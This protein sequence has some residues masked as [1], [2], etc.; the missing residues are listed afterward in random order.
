MNEVHVRD[1]LFAL[2]P[3]DTNGDWEDVLRRAAQEIQTR[4]SLPMASADLK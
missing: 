4:P 1:G 2:F 3:P